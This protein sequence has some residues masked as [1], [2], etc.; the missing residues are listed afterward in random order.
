[1]LTSAPVSYIPTDQAWTRITM[2]YRFKH[3]QTEQKMPL[4]ASRAVSQIL[5]ERYRGQHFCIL[6][7]GI[8]GL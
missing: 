8:Y 6:F 4:K 5:Q 1:M 3:R 2:N 7:G